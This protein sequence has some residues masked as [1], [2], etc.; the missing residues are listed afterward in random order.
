MG[1]MAMTGDARI[2]GGSVGNITIVVGGS[3]F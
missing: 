2:M 3:A 1:I